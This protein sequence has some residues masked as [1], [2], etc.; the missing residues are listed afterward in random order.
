MDYAGDKYQK[1]LYIGDGS[2]DF[3]SAMTLPENNLVMPRKGFKLEK[4]LQSQRIA[5]MDA[6]G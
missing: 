6:T 2:N 5:S 3:C 1:I 4:M